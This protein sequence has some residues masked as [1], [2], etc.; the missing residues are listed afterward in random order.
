[1]Q[2]CEEAMSSQ[3]IV[4]RHKKDWQKA[5]E[6]MREIVLNEL[7]GAGVDT[8]GFAWGL[9]QEATSPV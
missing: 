3:G 4:Y 7:W 2:A 9:E 6:P 5:E 8:A 1:M